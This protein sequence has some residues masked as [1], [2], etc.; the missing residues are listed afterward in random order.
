MSTVEQVRAINQALPQWAGID[1][2]ERA[3]KV[4]GWCEQNRIK[5]SL[6]AVA[7]QAAMKHMPRW[8]QGPDNYLD[9]IQAFDAANVAGP[10]HL[11]TIVGVLAPEF[12]PTR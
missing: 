10:A 3:Q 1:S 5:C 8:N 6:P 4:I 12:G 9:F 2:F 7:L 11:V